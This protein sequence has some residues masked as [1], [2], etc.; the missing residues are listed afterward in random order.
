VN[1]LSYANNLKRIFTKAGPAQ[2]ILFVTARCNFRCKMCFYWEEISEANAKKEIKFE[3]YA[4]LSSTMPEFPWL[5]IGGGEPFLR[6]D[7]ADIVTLFHK[8]NKIKNVTI[9]S[10]AS[11][12]ERMVE[13]I[14]AICSRNPDLF[15]NVDL[16]IQAVGDKHD[17]ICEFP[18]AWK[19]LIST[20]NRLTEVR[21]QFPNFGLGTIMTL[22]SLSQPYWR[23]TFEYILENFDFDHMVMSKTRGSPMVPE[24]KEVSLEEYRA[25]SKY[26]DDAVYAGRLKSF[27]FPLGQGLQAK[28]IVSRQLIAATTVENKAQLPC[29]AGKLNVVITENGD[30]YPCEL[31]DKKF[32]NLKDVDFDFQQLWNNQAANDTRK[33]IRNTKCFCTHECFMATN[34]LFNP[35]LYPRVAKEYLKIKM[36]PKAPPQRRKAAP[37]Y[38]EGETAIADSPSIAELAGTRSG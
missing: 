1:V 38:V 27:N 13:V 34:I 28:D 3:Q 17:E 32:G 25:A 19:K 2:V 24:S 26:I 9:P 11:L 21:R 20:Y 10:N 5:L 6:K 15:L 14:T 7:L 12:Q 4:K 36:A 22:S 37:V 23:H 30:L 33:F 16:S 35:R 31:L 29:H 8:N 18:G